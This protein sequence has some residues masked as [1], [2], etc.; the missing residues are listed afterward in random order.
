MQ[1]CS[2]VA[3]IENMC[4]YKTFRMFPLQLNVLVTFVLFTKV[5]VVVVVLAVM[6]TDTSTGW[7]NGSHTHAP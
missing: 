1:Q 7:M 6:K 2:N 5:P 4:Y 3:F